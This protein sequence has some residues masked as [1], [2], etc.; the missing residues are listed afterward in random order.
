M[1][2]V[3]VVRALATPPLEVLLRLYLQH[4]VGGDFVFDPGELAEAVVLDELPA[5]SHPLRALPIGLRLQ[6]LAAG[7]V[8]ELLSD[9]DTVPKMRYRLPVR[10]VRGSRES[11][12]ERLS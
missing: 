11:R 12:G 2:G 6:V 9:R 8:N 5:V 10:P 7:L 1:E 4:L 3:G